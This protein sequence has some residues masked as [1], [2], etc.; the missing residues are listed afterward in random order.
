MRWPS[1]YCWSWVVGSPLVFALFFAGLFLAGLEVKWAEELW[2][3]EKLHF[4]WFFVPTLIVLSLFAISLT[5]CPRCGRSA[6]T[7][8]TM[9]EGRMS[10]PQKRC[11]KCDLDLRAHTP[12]DRRAKATDRLR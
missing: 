5:F 12:F 7:K 6:L 3:V 2:G 10:F 11:S 4:G 8:G 9:F 1:V